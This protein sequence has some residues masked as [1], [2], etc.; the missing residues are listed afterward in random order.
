MELIF[1]I[2]NL[3]PEERDD[4]L[5]KIDLIKHN[6]CK[7]LKIDYSILK[8]NLNYILVEYNGD[9]LKTVLELVKLLSHIKVP[10]LNDID[11]TYIPVDHRLNPRISLVLTDEKTVKLYNGG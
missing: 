10:V 8:T 11:Y 4:I 7:E 9:D 5:P 6:I 3:Y 1:K 2:I